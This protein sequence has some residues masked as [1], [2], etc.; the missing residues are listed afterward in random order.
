MR[1]TDEGTRRDRTHDR[2]DL[3]ETASEGWHSVSRL[4]KVFRQFS[5][6]LL[7]SLL[8]TCISHPP[9][10]TLRLASRS[11]VR[12]AIQHGSRAYEKR[13]KSLAA[14]L[15]DASAENAPLT[16]LRVSTRETPYNE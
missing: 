7:S 16:G 2:V 3:R 1:E 13:T 6:V 15:Y 12:F 11:D 14:C 8:R 5:V 10:F 9:R 4:C